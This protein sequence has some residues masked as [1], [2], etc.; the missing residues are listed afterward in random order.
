MPLAVLRSRFVVCS[1]NLSYV[2]MFLL[3]LKQRTGID[4]FPDTEIRGGGGDRYVSGNESHK[5]N[6]EKRK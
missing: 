6:D 1:I 5:I 3:R 2:D 4:M